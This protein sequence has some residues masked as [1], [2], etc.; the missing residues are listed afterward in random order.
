M[1][2]HGHSYPLQNKYR[3]SVEQ[4]GMREPQTIA[5]AMTAMAALYIA[6]KI[7][8]SCV[9]N[10]SRLTGLRLDI[11]EMVFHDFDVAPVKDAWEKAII[12]LDDYRRFDLD[13]VEDRNI[14]NGLEQLEDAWYDP[15]VLYGSLEDATDDYDEIWASRQGYRDAMAAVRGMHHETM[16]QI[17]NHQ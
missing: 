14:A 6:R 2:G 7:Y 17:R 16:E 1:S 8:K 4:H 15:D 12:M 5:W 13:E 9:R 11:M 10:A 3:L